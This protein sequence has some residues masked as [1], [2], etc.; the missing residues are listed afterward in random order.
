MPLMPGVLSPGALVAGT[1]NVTTTNSNVAAPDSAWS[2]VSQT[3]LVRA[4]AGRRVL[5]FTWSSQTGAGRSAARLVLGSISNAATQSFGNFVS[6]TARGYNAGLEWFG[7][8][9][10]DCSDGVSVDVV[11]GTVDVA[12]YYIDVQ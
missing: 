4:R 1:A 2:A 9:G 7:P 3:R 12:V 11:T 6:D 5:G 8:A 10:L